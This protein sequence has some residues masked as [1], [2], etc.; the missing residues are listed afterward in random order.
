MYLI[1]FIT[2][3]PFYLCQSNK[4]LKSCKQNS[5]NDSNKGLTA[6]RIRFS[7]KGQVSD[8]LVFKCFQIVDFVLNLKCLLY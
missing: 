8:T 3:T 6:R 1:L 4:I 5:Q 2:S 7:D